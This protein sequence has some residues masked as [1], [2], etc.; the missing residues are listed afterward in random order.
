[1]ILDLVGNE[2]TRHWF[3]SAYDISALNDIERFPGGGYMISF[4]ELNGLSGA[5]YG[6]FVEKI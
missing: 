2:I 4:I 5:P 1:M 3:P 6:P